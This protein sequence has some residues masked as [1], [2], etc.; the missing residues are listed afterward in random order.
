[1]E[2]CR[3]ISISLFSVPSSPRS[4]STSRGRLTMQTRSSIA[5]LLLRVTLI[6]SSLV[7]LLPASAL[8]FVAVNAQANCRKINNIEVCDHFLQEWG[9]Q[10]SDQASIYV[11]G[12][13]IT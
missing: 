13:P 11:N 12:L 2:Q 6:G 10:G 8:S 9:K 3:P 4:E 7:M 1:M 5:G